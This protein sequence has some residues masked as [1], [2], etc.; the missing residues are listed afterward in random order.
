MAK[1]II[2]NGGQNNLQNK[3]VLKKLLVADF[4]YPEEAL[5][6]CVEQGLHNLLKQKSFVEGST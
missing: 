6:L 2:G 3:I 4:F 1:G 5:F